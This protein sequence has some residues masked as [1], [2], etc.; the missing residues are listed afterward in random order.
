M[1]SMLEKWFHRRFRVCHVCEASL[2]SRGF[3]SSASPLRLFAQHFNQRGLS[4]SSHLQLFPWSSRATASCLA[5][6]TSPVKPPPLAPVL[7][8][9]TLPTPFLFRYLTFPILRTL[10]HPHNYALRVPWLEKRGTRPTFIL[11][12]LVDTR[13]TSELMFLMS[14]SLVCPLHFFLFAR[15]VLSIVV[16]HAASMSRVS[17][18]FLAYR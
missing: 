16:S 17:D 11:A 10:R 5:S 8:P 6:F 1:T 4:L 14:L 3:S 15:S 2:T 9:H 18:W 13:P 7:L 12:L